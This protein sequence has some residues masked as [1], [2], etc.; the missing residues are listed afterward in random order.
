MRRL[1]SV[2]LGSTIVGIL[3]VSVHAADSRVPVPKPAEIAKSEVLVK[4]L[5]KAEYTK[6]K[7][8]DRA[9][10]AAKLIQQA[11]E[12]ADDPAS[13]YVLL[14]EARDV[15]AKA[16]DPSLTSKAADG[17]AEAFQVTAAAA[18]APAADTLAASAVSPPICRSVAETLLACTE[19]AMEAED[20]AS[21]GTLV[22]AATV[23][24]R[25]ATNLPLT[26][27]CTSTAKVIEAAQT[28]AAKVKKHLET[29]T[30]KPDDPEANLAVG[31]Y[32]CFFKRDWANGL[33]NL[34]KGSDEKLKAVAENDLEA[35]SE[36][37]QVAAGDAWFD[38]VSTAEGSA[39]L[40]SQLRAHTLYSEALPKLKGLTKSKVEKRVAELQPIVDART[41]RSKVWTAV[42]K[43]VSD[44]QTKK[45]ET[46]GGAFSK[47][48]FE[49]TPPNGAILVGFA[50]TT[51]S[52]GQYP[53][54]IQPIF[55]TS[56]GEV[57]G[58]VYGTIE[59]GAVVQTTKAKPGYAVGA[60]YTRGGGG[61]DAFKPIYMKITDTGLDPKE[62]YSGPHIGGQGG[63]EG[64][65]GGD[66]NFI[67]GIH[68]KVGTIPTW[69]MAAI[70]V[71]TVDPDSK[72]RK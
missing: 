11:S 66:G 39:K 5:F 18:L 31:R 50:Y 47:A 30:T 7:A 56:R 52:G 46:V 19:G 33:K 38:S 26:S 71:V 54:V 10:F 16:G 23:A 48:T 62:K 58:K 64:T 36:A 63:G 22:R 25:K 4:D 45:W 21:A 35:K 1:P 28:E 60:I 68:G 32:L 49:E 17:M 51:V 8:V 69:G 44:K 43:A 57:L 55:L 40:G 2:L 72:P 42:R 9:A 41:E 34:A 53:G 65:V 3:T 6:T 67:I 13:R 24:A 15:A 27:A 61:L 29:L 70:S 14:R 20:W 12:T 37:D 59:K